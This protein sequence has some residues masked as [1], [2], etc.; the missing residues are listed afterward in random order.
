MELKKEIEELARSLSASDVGFC[1][2]SLEEDGFSAAVCIAV[3]LSRTVIGEIESEPTYTYFHHY[4]TV[5][6][7]LDHIALRVGL[8]LGERGIP[9]LPVAASQSVPGKENGFSGR[10]SHKKAAVLSG[11]GQVG[12][13]N[14]FLHKK[15]GSAVRLVTVLFSPPD[16][17]P[18]EI[19][20]TERKNLCGDC[21]IC[22]EICPSGA[23]GS[24]AEHF[25]PQRC[26]DYMK[27]A[28]QHIGRGAVCGLCIRYCPSFERQGEK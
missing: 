8:L 21:T 18:E 10:F 2:L 25:N 6:A 26:S 24:D 11:M 22:K 16:E 7:L 19:G 28:F 9:Y 27:Q 12:K 5:N 17:L 14:L 3:A 15:Y 1:R 20:N 13:S 23:I 4:R